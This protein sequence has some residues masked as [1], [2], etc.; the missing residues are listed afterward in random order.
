M[1]VQNIIINEDVIIIVN[2]N[3]GQHI[4]PIDKNLSPIQKTHITN[5]KTYSE[6]LMNEFKETEF[7]DIDSDWDSTIA[8]GL[9]DMYDFQLKQ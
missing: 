4:I 3:G 9:D 8:D 2:T 7:N 1:E 6:L 5:I